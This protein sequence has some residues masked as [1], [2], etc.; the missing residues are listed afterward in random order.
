[1]RLLRLRFLIGALFVVTMLP[2]RSELREPV[3]LDLRQ[4][5]S[6]LMVANRRTGSLSVIDLDSHSVV[7]EIAIGKRLS[8]LK[9]VPG[10]ADEWLV[11]DEEAHEIMHLSG[12]AV[13]DRISVSDFPVKLAVSEDGQQIAVTSLWS[14]KLSLVKLKPR[15]HT[16][17]EITLSFSPRELLRWPGEQA[18]AI[19]ADAFGG[20]LAVVDLDLHE[21]LAVQ[22]L[23]AHNLR[24]LA[25]D[26]LKASLLVSHQRLNPLAYTNLGDTHWGVLM[27]NHLRTLSLSDLQRPEFDWLGGSHRVDLGGP[28][29]GAGDPGA[30]LIDSKG[31]LSVCLSGVNAV[32]IRKSGERRFRRVP[33]GIRPVALIEDPRSHRLYVAN[34]LS[35]SISVIDLS[36]V[37]VIAEISLGE[38]P[39]TLT[40]AERGERLFHDARLS[41]DGWMSCHSCHSNGHTNGQLADTHSD[42]SFDT[43][44]R[45]LSLLDVADTGPWAWNG[46]VKTLEAQIRQSVLKTMNGKTPLS[47][48]QVSEMHA[49]L[50]TLRPPPPARGLDHEA[51]RR[52][53]QV[54]EQLQCIRCHRPPQYTTPKAY[55]VGLADEMGND[56]F[57]P[58]SLRGVANR[59]AFF[60][61]GSATSLHEVLFT[62]RHQLE[63]T[64]SEEDVLSLITFL[65]SL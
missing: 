47:E 6:Q 37:Q 55:Q 3:S 5:P 26:H 15:L 29:D 63:D 36:S 28:A 13:K 49:Y 65:K 21:V 52:G 32:A 27:G 22:E 41:L 38:A 61:D 57:N 19:V 31:G 44:K 10:T 50:K 9:K 34:A 64:T 24:G 4:D 18:T 23:P 20:K 51:V 60:H 48:A 14:R 53:S 62:L 43:P 58:P 12:L 45:V 8:D 35:D 42:G 46:S 30:L 11:L 17:A 7:R 59:Q 39:L 40:K 2:G 16:V 54:L 25:I 1:M 33:V 56:H